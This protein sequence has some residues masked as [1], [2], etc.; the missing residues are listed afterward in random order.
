MSTKFIRSFKFLA[1][2]IVLSIVTSAG[3]SAADYLDDRGTLPDRQG[4]IFGGYVLYQPEDSHAQ[5]D[6]LSIN[7]FAWYPFGNNILIKSVDGELVATIFT[8][9][10]KNAGKLGVKFTISPTSSICMDNGF[11]NIKEAQTAI[12]NEARIRKVTLALR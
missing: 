2:L 8:L 5:K 3:Y 1:L 9:R 12:I 6:K 4:M 10:Y 11:N 7:S